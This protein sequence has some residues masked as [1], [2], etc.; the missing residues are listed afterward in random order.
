MPSGEPKVPIWYFSF[1][2]SI[3]VITKTTCHSQS[4]NSSNVIIL[5]YSPLQFH[6]FFSLLR[7]SVLTITLSQPLT[8]FYFLQVLCS[9]SL[10]LFCY[11]LWFYCNLLHL[12]FSLPFYFMLISSSR[13]LTILAP[14]VAPTPNQKPSSPVPINNPILLSN[15]LFTSDCRGSLCLLFHLFHLFHLF[16][17]HFYYAQINNVCS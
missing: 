2:G 10:W 7:F 14:K 1:P 11:L 5:V 4:Y 13:P 8:C 15:S 17:L 16:V 9:Y 12:I 3:N 6:L